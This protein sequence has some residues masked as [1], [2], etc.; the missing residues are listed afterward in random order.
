MV[1]KLVTLGNR[2][3]YYMILNGMTCLY[4]N[5]MYGRNIMRNAN[6]RNKRLYMYM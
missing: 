4:A 3:R 5:E 1:S 6:K 2:E